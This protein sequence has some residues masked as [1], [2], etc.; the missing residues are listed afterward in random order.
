MI[1][2]FFL[3]PTF[4]GLVVC[5]LAQLIICPSFFCIQTKNLENVISLEMLLL[6][7]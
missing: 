7:K 3:V 2:L 4:K 1:A 6:H 5:V